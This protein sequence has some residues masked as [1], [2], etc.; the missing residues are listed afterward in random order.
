MVFGAA[1]LNRPIVTAVVKEQHVKVLNLLYSELARE[2]VRMVWNTCCK[3]SYNQ[4][5]IFWRGLGNLRLYAYDNDRSRCREDRPFHTGRNGHELPA[6]NPRNHVGSLLTK[7]SINRGLKC[8]PGLRITVNIVSRLIL[9]RS[10]SLLLILGLKVLYTCT[11][12]PATR[13]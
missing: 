12:S 6:G 1:V 8:Y 5:Y 9:F 3:S 7:K 2:E 10:Q 11:W 4:N 13:V